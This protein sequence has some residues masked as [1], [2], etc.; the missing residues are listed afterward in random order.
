MW[1]YLIFGWNVG[2]YFLFSEVD[3]LELLSTLQKVEYF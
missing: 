3:F 2:M 1:L